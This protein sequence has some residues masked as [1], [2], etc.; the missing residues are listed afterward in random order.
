METRGRRGRTPCL[1]AIAR[2][3]LAAPLVPAPPHFGPSIGGL[4]LNRGVR[5]W[6]SVFRVPG[7]GNL[8]SQGLDQI[9]PLV[10]V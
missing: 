6:C 5:R 9:G 7:V 10:A 2:A 1:A 3:A 8:Q 4:L